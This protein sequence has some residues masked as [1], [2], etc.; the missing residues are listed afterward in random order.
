MSL[1]TR[2]IPSPDPKQVFCFSLSVAFSSFPLLIACLAKRS[3]YTGAAAK[4][5]QSCLTRCNRIDGSP[6][7]SPRQLHWSGLPF[8]SPM[9]E[10]EK[11]AQLGPTLSDPMDCSLPAFSVHGIFQARV[12]ELYRCRSSFLHIVLSLGN[13]LTKPHSTENGHLFMVSIKLLMWLH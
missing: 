13:L 1:R 2:Q 12:L 8:P 7:G 6:P 9:H 10:N 3:F 5:L 11:C 4:S